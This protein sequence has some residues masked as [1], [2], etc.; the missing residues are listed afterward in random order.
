MN[1]EERQRYALDGIEV[2]V[3]EVMHSRASVADAEPADGTEADVDF[4]DGRFT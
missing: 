1:D 3:R 2:A 4:T